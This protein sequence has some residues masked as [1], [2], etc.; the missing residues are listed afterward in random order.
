MFNIVSL[1]LII[2]SALVILII[3]VRK[4]PALAILNVVNIPG[5]EEAKFKHKIIKARVER[6]L[7]RWSG[8][9]GRAWLFLKRHF[10]AFLRAQQ[11]S[12]EKMKVSYNTR[13]KVP[14]LER[15]KRIHKLLLAAQ[16]FLKKEDEN[17][18][19]KKLVEII[20]LDQKNLKA[21][22]LLA[23]LYV[24]Q[25]KWSE[26]RQTY[27]YAL[28]LAREQ[29]Q[30]E[31]AKEITSQEIYFALAK[32]EKVVDNLE[33][34]LENIREALE[35]EPNNPR[36]LDL[37]LDLSIMRKDKKLAQEFWHKLVSINPENHKLAEWEKSIK[38]L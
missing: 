2:L 14:W 6:D 18:A 36:Y 31:S 29:D 24:G 33:S 23:D 16:E 1:I 5:E 38:N 26:A 11:A 10:G 8:F 28:K 15:Q 35:L 34:A 21:F 13:I 30:T 37:V 17:L 9:L 32:L 27:E 22:F 7:T 3:I 19:E 25:K 12:L 20:S 4:F